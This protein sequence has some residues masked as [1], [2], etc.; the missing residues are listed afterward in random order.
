MSDSDQRV[1]HSAAPLGEAPNSRA[2]SNYVLGI[3]FLV[4]ILNFVDRQV[5]SI[6]LQDIKED[7]GV[8]D[9]AMGFL[10]GIAFALFYTVAGI[11]IARWADVGVRRSIIAGG[12][13]IWSVMTALSGLAQNFVHL[14]VL[15]SESPAQNRNC[16][17]RVGAPAHEN[18]QGGVIALQVGEEAG[19][20]VA[21][22]D[23]AK[24]ES[25]SKP[26]FVPT[27]AGT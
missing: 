24:C 9:T 18:V 20:P 23:A 4:Y 25:G 27:P 8:S 17:L 2:Y 3:L 16:P 15:G 11:P 14:N 22:V 7:L 10:T 26:F 5:I 13:A 1:S 21:A 12:I 19:Q 6:L